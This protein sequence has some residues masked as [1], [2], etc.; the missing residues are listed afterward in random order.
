MKKQQGTINDALVKSP[1]SP[2]PGGGRVGVGVTRYRIPEC[3]SPLPFILS[4]RPFGSAR[5]G[6]IYF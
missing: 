5:G 6:K 3:Y 2:P 4:F 1:K